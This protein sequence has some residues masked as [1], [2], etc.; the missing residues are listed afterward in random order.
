MSQDETAADDGPP[1]K[2]GR[3]G[4]P[5]SWKGIGSGGNAVVWSDGCRA[6]K[7]LESRAGAEALKRFEREAKLLESL[8]QAPGL[9]IVPVYE[10]RRRAD[11]LEI[12]ME[13]MDG[14]LEKIL[15]LYAGRPR[16]AAQALLPIV[17]TLAELA[18]RDRP[19]HHRDIKPSNILY[20]RA[21]ETIMLFLSDFGCAYLAG[22]ERLTTTHRAVG[23]RAY[24]S[25]EYSRGRVEEVTDKGD[26]FSLGKVLW[27]MING[28]KG[29]FFPGPVWYTDEFDLARRFPDSDGI[30]HAMLVIGQAASVDPARRP[31]LT[32]FGQMLRSLSEDTAPVTSTDAR[33]LSILRGE[34]VRE[35]AYDQRRAFTAKFVRALHGDLHDALKHLAESIPESQLFAAWYR[36]ATTTPQTADAVESQVAVQESDATVVVV[37]RWR[38]LFYSRFYPGGDSMPASFVVHLGSEDQGTNA[39]SDFTVIAE[40]TGLQV[41]WRHFDESATH[42]EP[43]RPALLIEFLATAVAKLLPPT[44]SSQ[45]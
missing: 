44:S 29:E 5:R 7:R 43:Y 35:V 45:E 8:K 19:L 42:R 38:L 22:D 34:Q 33:R 28:Q 17:E 25:P 27:A 12:V 15:H 40:S 32:E 14:N 31:S 9:A 18:S 4:I 10:V 37:R 21:G 20:R 30:E 23:A 26:V 1:W 41:E 2:T 11:A 16:E 6:I 36:E 24:Q 13:E 39:T 3:P